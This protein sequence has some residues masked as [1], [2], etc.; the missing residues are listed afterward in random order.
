MSP[1]GSGRLRP[2][3]LVAVAA[4]AVCVL[5]LAA[6]GSG[7]SAGSTPTET[8]TGE[9]QFGTD[10]P[11]DEPA[12]ASTAPPAGGGGGGGTSGGGGGGGG[13]N[14]SQYPGNAA[15]YGLEMLKAI[16]AGDDARIVDL[17]SLATAQYINDQNYKARNGQWTHATCESGSCSYYNQTGDLASVGIDSSRL[18][19]QSAVTSVSIEGRSFATDA[20][21]YAQDLA[22]AW[23]FDGRYVLLRSLATQPVVDALSGKQ[24]LNAGGGGVGA[25]PTSCPAGLSGTCVEV[26]AVGGS[27]T[28][29][30]VFAVD[31][32]RLGQPNA[33]TGV[34]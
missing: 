9:G 11:T 17:S 10:A 14:A 26:Y 8:A 22:S 21:G 12:P 32:G 13:G 18:G 31:P 27:P 16:A 29:S 2:S 7:R 30:Y 5:A 3:R 23:T 1:S 34:S 24:K 25:Q 33:V 6:C 19:Q 15:D 28:I 20:V 4:A